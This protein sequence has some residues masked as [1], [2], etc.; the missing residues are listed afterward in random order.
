MYA[1]C[2]QDV[3]EMRRKGIAKAKTKI[4]IRCTQAP[5]W[6]GKLIGALRHHDV[7]LNGGAL[8]HHI[9]KGKL[10]GALRHHDVK[11]NGGALRHHIDKGKL[12][13][14]LRHGRTRGQGM[15][16]HRRH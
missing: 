13:G 1:R 4:L 5:H 8:R 7:K 9:E 3:G 16:T 2:R 15:G 10:I 11:L 14:A 6:K 12:I